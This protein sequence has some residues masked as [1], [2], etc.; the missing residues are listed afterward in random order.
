MQI[1]KIELD[2]G[3]QRLLV[4]ANS[5]P[6]SVGVQRGVVLWILTDPAATDMIEPTGEV[7]MTG[8]EISPDIGRFLGTAQLSSGI[9]AHVFVR[10]WPVSMF[11]RSPKASGTGSPGPKSP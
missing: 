8:P 6:L 2:P 5:T 3:V 4:S 9:V 1:W 7:V 11:A 10:D